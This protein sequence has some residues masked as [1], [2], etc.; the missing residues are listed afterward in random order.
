MC[1]HMGCRSTSPSLHGG[2][3][4]LALPGEARDSSVT[5]QHLP[6]LVRETDR[7]WALPG[8]QPHALCLE[9]ASR[10]AVMFTAHCKQGG[11]TSV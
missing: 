1:R 8:Q 7:E 4:A 9:T 5:R 10:R 11:A 6:A 2:F 3:W